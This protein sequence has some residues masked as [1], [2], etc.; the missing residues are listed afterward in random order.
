MALFAAEA[1]ILMVLVIHVSGKG[2][3]SVKSPCQ[4]LGFRF[5]SWQRR[6]FIQW[7]PKDSGYLVDNRSPLCLSSYGVQPYEMLFSR[8][9]LPSLTSLSISSPKRV[10]C[11]A[12]HSRVNLSG[13][14]TLNDS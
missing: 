10:F 9:I 8:S 4:G 7:K 5:C 3:L 12:N 11:Q 13:L 14:L 6:N 2:V 1:R